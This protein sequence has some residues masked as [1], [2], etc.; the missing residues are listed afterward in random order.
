[1]K[2]QARI[3]KVVEAVTSA[4]SEKTRGEKIADAVSG[5]GSKVV[6]VAKQVPEKV[7]VEAVAAVAAGVGVGYAATKLL[8]GEDDNT[9]VEETPEDGTAEDGFD[10][11]PDAARE[12]RRN[13]RKQRGH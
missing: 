2:D 9:E 12:Q 3:E 8:S 1:M 11:D 6:D 13:A 5:A 7:P 10:H 4:L